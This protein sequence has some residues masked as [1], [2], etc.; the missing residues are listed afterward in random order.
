MTSPI[1]AIGDIHGQLEMLQHALHLIERDGGRDAQIV[2]IGDYVDRGPDSRGVL[3]HLANAKQAG[4][5][6]TFLLGNHDRMFARFLHDGSPAEAKLRVGEHWL[7]ERLG[8]TETLASYGVDFEPDER[9][10]RILDRVQAA[11]PQD[12]IDFLAKLATHHLSGELL[13]AH[14][15][16]RP[17]IP[18]ADQSEED[19]IWIRQEF[20]EDPR[21]HPYL[22]VHGHTPAQR[23]EHR[24]NRINLDGGAGMGRP[25][26]PAV[27]EGRDCWLLTDDGRV[28]LIPLE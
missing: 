17:G 26:V 15:G 27:F 16:I 28:P 2:F 4:R 21:P 3:D 25:L 1:Y 13:F 11:V 20:L 9:F 19:L 12:H 14:A 5:N 23:A 24:G 10:Y 22:I 8:G 6:W 18:V 7:H